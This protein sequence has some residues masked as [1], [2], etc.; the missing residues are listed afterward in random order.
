MQLTDVVRNYDWAA[1]R[2]DRWTDLVFGRLL[3]VERYREKTIDLL[4]SLEGA[5][6]LDVGCGTGRN[7][8]ILAPRVGAGGRIIGLDYSEGMLARARERVEAH[9]W[10]NVELLRG[11]AAKL[12]GVPQNVDAIVSIWC[13]GIVY[14]LEAAL[15][16]SLHVL[17]PGGRIAIMDFTRSRPDHGPLHWLYPFYSFVLTRGGI[18]SPEDLDDAA[19]QQRWERGRRLL[20]ER[21]TGVHE[22]TYLHGG[23]LI[24]AGEKPLA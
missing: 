15:R 24:I 13:L 22:E 23:G 21:L 2:Y 18:D 7:F 10:A 14:D 16:R 3:G 4:G 17:R 1:R 20:Y 12:E 6:V 9:G 11:D 5:T 8:P 19:L